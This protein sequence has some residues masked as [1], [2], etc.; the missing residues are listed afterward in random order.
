MTCTCDKKCPTCGAPVR[1][2]PHCH[3]VVYEKPEVKPEVVPG[4]PYGYPY[5]APHYPEEYRITCD[6]GTAARPEPV[7]HNTCC[8]NKGCIE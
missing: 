4:Y 1:V 7:G 2:C 3:E 6:D 8:T 5:T